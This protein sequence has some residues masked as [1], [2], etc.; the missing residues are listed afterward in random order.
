M[1]LTS[2]AIVTAL[3]SIVTALTDGPIAVSYAHILHSVINGTLPRSLNDEGTITVNIV[4]NKKREVNDPYYSNLKYLSLD[5]FAKVN[6]LASL[7]LSAVANSAWGDVLYLYN[8]VRF[9]G[10]DDYMT[11]TADGK[12]ADEVNL[13]LL[14]TPDQSVSLLSNTSTNS[15]LKDYYAS[16][17]PN[18]SSVI[19]VGMTELVTNSCETILRQMFYS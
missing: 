19:L 8:Y 18:P 3:I 17:A 2:I 14:S 15:V 9:N 13:Y 7:L 5:N 11:L 6:T 16:F 12:F 10:F 1:N 4:A